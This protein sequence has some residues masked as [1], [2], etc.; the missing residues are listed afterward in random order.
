VIASA[1]IPATARLRVD[2]GA[3]ARLSMATGGSASIDAAGRS[4]PD[5]ASG[6]EGRQAGAVSSGGEKAP[7]VEDSVGL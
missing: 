6:T 1:A 5:G 7:G 3:G 2:R 4:D